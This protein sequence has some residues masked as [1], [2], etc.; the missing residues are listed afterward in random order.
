MSIYPHE[1]D[2]KCIQWIFSQSFYIVQNYFHVHTFKITYAM[3]STIKMCCYIYSINGISIF[4]PNNHCSCIQ[5]L[6][7]RLSYIVLLTIIEVN[8]FIWK[9]SLHCDSVNVSF[10][11]NNEISPRIIELQC[12]YMF[13][14]HFLE[15]SMGSSAGRLVGWIRM[16]QRFLLI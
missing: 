16:S 14:L 5:K 7:F 2:S 12:E 11:Q 9:T 4:T 6:L 15:A 10:L 13:L 1:R 8:V 3:I